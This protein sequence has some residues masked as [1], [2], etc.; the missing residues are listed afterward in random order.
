[1]LMNKKIIIIIG[2][3]ALFIFLI[4]KHYEH[5]KSISESGVYVIGN[6]DKTRT[7][8]KGI[9][10]YVSYQYRGEQITSDFVSNEIEM[11]DQ[12]KRKFFKIHPKY[13]W[14]YHIE[15]EV[16]VPDYLQLS[17]YNGWD[18]LPVEGFNTRKYFKFNS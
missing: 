16:P 9:K 17:P 5:H 12:G 11:S 13:P 14:K 2:V 8:Y 18:T 4:I 6:I 7:A 10:T 15:Y 3:V 1:M